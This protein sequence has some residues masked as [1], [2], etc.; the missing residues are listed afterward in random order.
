MLW[1]AIFLSW[2]LIICMEQEH[3]EAVWSKKECCDVKQVI[4]QLTKVILLLLRVVGLVALSVD[5][6]LRLHLLRLANANF[7]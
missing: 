2:L 1:K 7:L 6:F 5:L 3:E 4:M